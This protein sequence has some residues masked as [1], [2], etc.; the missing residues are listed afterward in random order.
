MI[1]QQ[2]FLRLV[3]IPTKENI[4]SIFIWDPTIPKIYQ[5]KN[6]IVGN[7]ASCF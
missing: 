5:A 6:P 2:H 1:C 3:R 4:L 7:I